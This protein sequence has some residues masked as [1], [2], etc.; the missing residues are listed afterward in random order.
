MTELVTLA[1]TLCLGGQQRR[2]KHRSTVNSCDMTFSI[3]IPPGVNARHPASVLYWLSGLT[4]SDENFMQKAGAQRKAAELGMILVAPDTSPRGQDVASDPENNWDLG[5]GAGFYINATQAPW[6]KH[7]HMFDYVTHEL[8]ALINKHFPVNRFASISG[9]SMGGHGALIC[10]LKKP[11][12]YQSVSAFAPIANP[13]N[14]PW[15]VKAFTHYL[16]NDTS[17]WGRYDACELLKS[18][19]QLPPTMI[20]Q[21]SEDVFLDNQ[22]NFDALVAATR[23]QENK[24]SIKLRAGYDH[25]YYYIA[26]FIQNH[27]EFHARYLNKHEH[28][29]NK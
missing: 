28:Q 2:Y 10:A 18:G 9:H 22:L 1:S 13:T 24:I 8:P 27:L 26:S 3:Y 29:L 25:S 14:C 15:G 7:Y 11:G 5:L 20:D 6:Q 21:G 4:C 16:G 17:T 19:A 12:H 23:K